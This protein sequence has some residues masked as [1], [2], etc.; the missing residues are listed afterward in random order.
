MFFI[1]LNERS[2]ASIRLRESF[3]FH[4]VLI[5]AEGLDNHSVPVVGQERG[6][7][8]GD[9]VQISID[10]DSGF[11]PQ[12]HVEGGSMARQADTLEPS[13]MIQVGGVLNMD[14]EVLPNKG[15]QPLPRLFRYAQVNSH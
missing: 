13:D 9:Y 3:L 10:V 1:E 12:D 4:S 8:E 14:V 11:A 2:V 6:P 7:I 5:K 15:E